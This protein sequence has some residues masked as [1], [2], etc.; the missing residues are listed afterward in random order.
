MR[1]CN[2]SGV[3]WVSG[4]FSC[5]EDHHRLLQTGSLVD[6][7]RTLWDMHPWSCLGLFLPLCNTVYG[8]CMS[9]FSCCL[10][11]TVCYMCAVTQIQAEEISGSGNRWSKPTP[12]S[13]GSS[14]FPYLTDVFQRPRVPLTKLFSTCSLPI[15]HSA[16]L[17]SLRLRQ[18]GLS[19]L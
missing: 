18:E 5:W 15:S 14:T 1:L 17:Y 16:Q 2:E 6:I 19:S 9:S 11:I 4:P 10:A 3:P 13:S 8:A 7:A 12:S